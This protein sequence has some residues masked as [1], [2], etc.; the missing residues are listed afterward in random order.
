[1]VTLETAVAGIHHC[2]NRLLRD[3]RLEGLFVAGAI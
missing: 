1:M 2:G 3:K